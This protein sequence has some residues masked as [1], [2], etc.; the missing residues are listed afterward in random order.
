M[1][2]SVNSIKCL[3][4]KYRIQKDLH[5]KMI[6]HVSQGDQLVLFLELI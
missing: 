5:Q 2:P 6:L 4:W 1:P 3:V